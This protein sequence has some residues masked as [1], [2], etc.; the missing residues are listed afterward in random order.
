MCLISYRSEPLTAKEDI[1]CYK[2][3]QRLDDNCYVS[4]FRNMPY[5][6]NSV[7]Y[8]ETVFSESDIKE[9]YLYD[10][11]YNIGNGFLHCYRSCGV[12]LSYYNFK[13]QISYLLYLFECYIPKGAKYFIN[14][15]GTEI[16][17]DKLFVKDIKSSI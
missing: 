11:C 3:L 2:V 7:N 12:A 6:I 4:P 9:Y 5:K 14:R 15:N 13:Q 1:P 17:A 16:C 8:P 10:Y